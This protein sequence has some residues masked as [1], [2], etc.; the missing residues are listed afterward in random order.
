MVVGTRADLA[1]P[2]RTGARGCVLAGGARRDMLLACRRR[3]GRSDAPVAAVGVP[4]PAS[5]TELDGRSRGAR[6]I[7]RSSTNSRRRPQAA[8]TSSCARSSASSRIAGSTW[9]RNRISGQTPACLFNSFN[10]DFAPAAAVRRPWGRADGAPRRR[11]DRRLP[12]VR[13]R[14]RRT[15]RG[16]QRR[17]GRRNDPAVAVQPREAP[18]ARDRAARPGRHHERRRSGDLPPPGRQS[19]STAS[20]QGDRLELVRQSPKGRRDPRMAR[21]EARPRALR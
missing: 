13:R 16:G 7:W 10:F 9:S 6:P 12:W 8:G 11:P 18:R 20:A 17:A 5:G 15:D 2:P 1:G 19:R 3:A 14:H 21:P 4:R